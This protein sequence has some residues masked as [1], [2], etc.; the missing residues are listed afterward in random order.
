MPSPDSAI[1]IIFIPTSQNGFDG[2]IAADEQ[3]GADIRP[4]RN[5]AKT[6][7]S[8]DKAVQNLNAS[9]QN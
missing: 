1:R 8:V 3:S 9:G 4:V 2:G 6:T 7:S 5:W